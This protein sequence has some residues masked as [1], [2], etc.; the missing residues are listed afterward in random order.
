MTAPKI[1]SLTR[2]CTACPS[3]WEG[4]LEDGRHAYIRLRHGHGRI[5][6]G[7][8]KDEAVAAQGFYRWSDPEHDGFITDWELRQ[9]LFDASIDLAPG[10]IP[11]VCGIDHNGPNFGRGNCSVCGEPAGPAARA[12][13]DARLK[14]QLD[15]LRKWRGE[16]QT[17]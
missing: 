11:D 2:T 14:S 13:A 1:V 16:D 12:E 5:G 9:E 17:S 15:T 3:Q 4:R 10:V 6:F 7:S 8:T